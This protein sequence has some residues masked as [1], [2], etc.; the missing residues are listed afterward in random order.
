MATATVLAPHDVNTTLNYLKLVGDEAPF[1]YM[2]ILPEGQSTTNIQ[3]DLRPAVIHDIRGQED[4][5]SLD[6]TGFG[7]IKHVSEEKEF[8]NEEVITTRY[9]KEVEKL[10]KKHTGAKRVFVFDHTIR[11]DF[12]YCS[13]SVA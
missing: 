11:C 1:N 8:V 9:Y 5:V 3:S 2:Y 13:V 4:T 7:F 6:T 10:L 12:F